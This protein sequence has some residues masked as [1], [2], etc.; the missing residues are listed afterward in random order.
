MQRAV[1]PSPVGAAVIFL[2][3]ALSTASCSAP[4]V[5]EPGEIQLCACLSGDAGLQECEADGTAWGDC[6]CTSGG[7]GGN[8]EPQY[9]TYSCNVSRSC[10]GVTTPYDNSFGLACALSATE[11]REK[12]DSSACG[13]TSCFCSVSGCSSSGGSCTP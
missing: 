3:L 5:C 10:P 4:Q 6:L 13:N 9:T 11:A 2:S 7:G 1:Q 12:V 8:N